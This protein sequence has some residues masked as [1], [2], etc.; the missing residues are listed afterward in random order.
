MTIVKEHVPGTTLIVVSATNTD[1]VLGI[2]NVELH[3]TCTTP[4]QDDNTSP[5]HVAYALPLVE[6]ASA[7]LNS[8]KLYVEAAKS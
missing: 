5:N 2:T 4:G 3:T 6:V 7:K 1:A 8:K